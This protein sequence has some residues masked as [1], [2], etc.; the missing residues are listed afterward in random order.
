MGSGKNVDFVGEFFDSFD[1][2][3]NFRKQIEAYAENSVSHKKI[4]SSRYNEVFQRNANISA[5]CESY[6]KCVITFERADFSL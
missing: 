6:Q 2:L 3:N 5:K 1:F 4:S